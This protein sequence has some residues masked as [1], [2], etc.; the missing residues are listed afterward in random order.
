MTAFVNAVPLFVKIIVFLITVLFLIFGFYE[1][2]MGPED[3]KKLLKKMHI[4][5]RYPIILIVGFVF[6]SLSCIFILWGAT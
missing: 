1:E 5:F 2:L 3:A 4:P 6:F